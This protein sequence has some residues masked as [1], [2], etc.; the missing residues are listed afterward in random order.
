[1]DRRRVL[2]TGSRLWALVIVLGWAFSAFAVQGGPV[3][4]DV[5][6]RTVAGSACSASAST[7][8]VR[9]DSAN[10]KLWCCVAS[11]WEACG[12]TFDPMNL[13][14]QF[15]LT[16]PDSG[17]GPFTDHALFTFQKPP[18]SPTV[19]AGQEVRSL[20]LYGMGLSIHNTY[21]T[22]GL[23][24]MPE[25]FP[26][27]GW[28]QTM[29]DFH[30][31]QS[32]MSG[33]SLDYPHIN[34]TNIDDNYIGLHLGSEQ[35]GLMVRN[36]P[37]N[38]ALLEIGAG[39][40]PYVEGG[41]PR[42]WTPGN[43]DPAPYPFGSLIIDSA[44][45]VA[46]TAPRVSISNPTLAWDDGV[47]PVSTITSDSQGLQLLSGGATWLTTGDRFRFV[48]TQNYGPDQNI[49][50]LM[51]G[52]EGVPGPDPW[53]MEIRFDSV[54]SSG[55][56]QT[57]GAIGAS[58]S[59]DGDS[60]IGLGNGGNYEFKVHT[61]PASRMTMDGPVQATLF[62]PDESALSTCDAAAEGELRR[63]AGTGGT[64]TGART[65]LCLCASDGGASPAYAW[66]NVVT[67]TIGNATTCSP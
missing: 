52:V 38:R 62:K 43:P 66:Q 6:P 39:A 30:V 61:A 51:T 47:N 67:G 32:D 22:D 7:G 46:I 29:I 44:V 28:P 4:A 2:I 24:L 36:G 63:L 14:T 18:L 50:V 58:G 27:L 35:A 3:Y 12:T 34:A 8:R 60:F 42:V 54:D 13:G 49:L 55:D 15:K 56:A 53:G 5:A 19:S 57:I 9:I 21:G 23:H 33:N 59:S 1:M 20:G 64:N 37:G 31:M 16:N 26:G 17:G 48:K 25:T 11:Q 40:N 65:R 10:G 41:I 45:E